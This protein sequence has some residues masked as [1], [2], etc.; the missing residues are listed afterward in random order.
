[1]VTARLRLR[2]LSPAMPNAIDHA[3]RPRW[4][5]SQMASIDV[6]EQAD[7]ESVEDGAATR[8]RL[9]IFMHRQPYAEHELE[10]R[11]QHALEVA[12]APRQRHLA[13][14]DSEPARITISCARSLSVLKAK[15]TASS[16]C[17][18]ASVSA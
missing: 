13:N 15:C 16:P 17:I 1:M 8:R 5:I 9:E 10:S 2:R 6:R 18:A 7:R 12:V 14:A 11:R 3:H 4:L